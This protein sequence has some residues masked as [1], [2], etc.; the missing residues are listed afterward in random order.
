MYIII[1]GGGRIGFFLAKRLRKDKH[2]VVIVEKNAE[3]AEEITRELDAIV[4]HGDGCEPTVL[5]QAGVGRAHVVAAVTGYDED[6]FIICQIA[7]EQFKVSRTVGRVNDPE[8]ERAFNELGID[9]PVGATAILA[10]IIEEEV[11]FSD[12][13][14]L[15]SFKRG[16][17][18]L[19]RVDL[20]ESSPIIN[21]KLQD[22]KLPPNSVLVSVIR[23]D[24]I[25]VPKGDTVLN[26]MDDV[27]ALTLVENKQQLLNYLIGKI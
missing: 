15:F 18:A 13:V 17:L 26:P 12:F 9:V 27:I 2:V 6:N 11:S 14:D 21:K 19:I 24:E 7:K 4:I 5:E 20:P 16:K 23:G 10:K 8:N 22:L 25:I 1:V 3:T